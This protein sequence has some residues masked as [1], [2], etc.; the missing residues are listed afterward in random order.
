MHVEG[1]LHRREPSLHRY[2]TVVRRASC[3]LHRV[4]GFCVAR[5]GASLRS[6]VLRR[7]RSTRACRKRT[8][9]RAGS[10]RS[11]RHS[12]HCTGERLLPFDARPWCD[13]Q[14]EAYNT[15]PA[16]AS[17]ARARHDAGCLSGGGTSREPAA[18]ARR[19]AQVVVGLLAMEGQCPG[20]RSLSG[21]A[22]PRC[23]VPAASSSLRSRLMH[24]ARGRATV[25]A[26]S[27]EQAEYASLPCA[28][29]VPRRLWSVCVL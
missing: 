2:K 6:L 7:R 27:R 22:K 21:G 9:Y 13:V 14:A 29:G 8:T 25:L 18:C 4:A 17:R 28:S 11:M 23:D 5:E 12:K 20:E 15:R 24:R 1:A 3:S 16:S 10:S 19:A 26:V